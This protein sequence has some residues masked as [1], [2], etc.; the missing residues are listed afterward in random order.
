MFPPFDNCPSMVARETGP[1]GRDVPEERRVAGHVFLPCRWS[2]SGKA[3]MLARRAPP[4]RR[5]AE[6]M[7]AGGRP[8][9]WDRARALLERANELPEG[10]R[11]AFLVRECATNAD[12]RREVE[13]ML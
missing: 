13:S 12:M 9:V 11:A 2:R 4:T 8:C 10:E 3:A 1:G 7:G 6:P 5:I